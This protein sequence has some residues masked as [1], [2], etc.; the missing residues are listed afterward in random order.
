MAP[1]QL[2]A[3]CF[4]NIFEVE[5]APF[6]GH[7]RVHDNVEEQIA[8]L[9]T[10]IRVVRFFD[11]F[12]R[13]VAFLDEGGSQALM[14]LLAIPRTAPR[15][16]QPGDDFPQAGDVAHVRHAKANFSSR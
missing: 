7:L 15:R 12:D 16:A 8:E 10:Q 4:D 3:D 5:G 14:G 9:F 2:S 1:N 13:F 11:C 6:L